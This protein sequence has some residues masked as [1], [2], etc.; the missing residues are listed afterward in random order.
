MFLSGISGP[1]PPT[2]ELCLNENLNMQFYIYRARLALYECT[3][4][5]GCEGSL[6]WFP[7]CVLA[8]RWDVGVRQCTT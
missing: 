3:V 6:T 4:R 5:R 8:A 1:K 2:E 7:L